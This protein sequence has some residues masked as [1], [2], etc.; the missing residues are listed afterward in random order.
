MAT[1]VGVNEAAL[2]RM[3]QKALE[4]QRTRLLP[5]P[6]IWSLKNGSFQMSQTSGSLPRFSRFVYLFANVYISVCVLI[7][8]RCNCLP[9]CLQPQVKNI[10]S[11]DNIDEDS[12]R[13]V[14]E[15][16]GLQVRSVA[17]DTVKILDRRVAY[18]RLQ[19]PPLPWKVQDKQETDVS[20]IAI[21]V[22]KRL[23]EA[24]PPLQLGEDKLQF[25][26]SHPQVQL[27]IGNITE[28]WSDDV[29]LRNKMEEYGPVERC[30]VVHNH[31]GQTKVLSQ[32]VSC[33]R[34]RI[35]VSCRT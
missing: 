25:D 10:P 13:E 28:E 34:Y 2:Y 17:F 20:K 35:C 31:K 3:P 1:V 7:S 26:T 6:R 5:T 24:D 11:A 22:V 27:F 4:Q 8:E 33:C 15:A 16:A 9:P 23:K 30:L 32:P 19:P 14:L 21:A 29:S 18:V 12:V